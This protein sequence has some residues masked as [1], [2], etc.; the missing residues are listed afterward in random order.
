MRKYFKDILLILKKHQVILGMT[1]HVVFV[2]TWDHRSGSLLFSRWVQF[3]FARV[4][5]ER[6]FRLLTRLN[7]FD[8][9]ETMLL[10]VILLIVV[11]EQKKI[12]YHLKRSAEFYSSSASKDRNQSGPPLAFLHFLID[13][14]KD[15]Q[16]QYRR[17]SLPIPRKRATCVSA[18]R[19]KWQLS[20]DVE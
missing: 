17:P 6:I 7:H 20:T 13:V 2:W 18:L 14:E 4:E 12:N 1:A 16:K 19:M 15:I 9:G 10:P 3:P 8:S 5:S 11:S